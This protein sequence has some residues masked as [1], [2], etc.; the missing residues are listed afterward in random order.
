MQFLFCKCQNFLYI[1]IDVWKLKKKKTYF[2]LWIFTWKDPFHDCRYPLNI[3]LTPRMWNHILLCFSQQRYVSFNWIKTVN[4]FTLT[5]FG[6]ELNFFR[7]RRFKKLCFRAIIFSVFFYFIT[8][9][10]GGFRMLL[11]WGGHPK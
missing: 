9:I 4:H 10:V 3:V 7:C 11:E 2:H 5:D 8:L 6:W 1:V